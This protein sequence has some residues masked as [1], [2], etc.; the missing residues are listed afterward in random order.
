MGLVGVLLQIIGA[1]LVILGGG[2]GL[3]IYVVLSAATS[4]FADG[5]HL[6]NHA[7]FLLYPLVPSALGVAVYAT[8]YAV[9][10]K[11]RAG[12]H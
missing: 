11:A 12:V 8:G 3:Y 6:T 5:L 1:A 2:A 9:S 4:V 10:A 7:A